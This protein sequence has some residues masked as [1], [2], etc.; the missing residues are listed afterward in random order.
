MPW[1]RNRTRDYSRSLSS[2]GKDSNK[3]ASVGIEAAVA[4]VA[5]AAVKTAAVVVAMAVDVGAVIIPGAAA[6]AVAEDG[7]HAIERLEHVEESVKNVILKSIN[8]L[9]KNLK[10]LITHLREMEN[11]INRFQNTQFLLRRKRSFPELMPQK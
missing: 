10:S 9:T 3:I 7:S 5:T 1:T 8:S 2:I 11:L 6:E 4:A